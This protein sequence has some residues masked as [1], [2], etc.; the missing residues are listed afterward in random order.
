MNTN[1]KYAACGI[2]GGALIMLANIMIHI[3][4]SI[5]GENP[6]TGW[7]SVSNMLFGISEFIALVGAVGSLMGC[8]STHHTAAETCGKKMKVLSLLPIVGIV[9]MPLF[10]GN[11][12]Y[13]EPLI[14]QVLDKHGQ[15]SIY[16]D[17]DSII[18]SSFAPAD[19]LILVTFYSQ[20]IVLFYGVLS[21]R[22]GVKKWFLIFDPIVFLII[23]AVISS[24]LPASVSGIGLG[25]RNLGEGLMY[26]IPFAYRKNRA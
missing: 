3:G 21:G 14:Y 23:G 8:I 11:I 25:M 24:I 22:F 17:M 10:H 6:D 9:G 15:Q 16:G 1:R 5:T 18:S 26:I 12:N 7:T 2:A 4:G 13:I 20:L 19:L